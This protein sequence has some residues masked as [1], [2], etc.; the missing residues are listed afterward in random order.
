MYKVIIFDFDRTIGTLV[1]DWTNWRKNIKDLVLELEPDSDIKLEDIK[2]SNQNGLILK[3]GSEF[4]ERLNHINEQS[5]Q[6]LVTN[7]LVNKAVLDY[8]KSTDS[9]LYCWSSNSKK[10]LNKYL[11][12][13]GVI[14]RF[15]KIISREDTNLLKPDNEGFKL[16]HNQEVPLEQYLFVGDSDADKVA[17]E[18]SGII[19]MHIDDFA[20]E[21]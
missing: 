11:A 12:E 6:T 4:R 9:E 2:H 20:L 17:A 21:T 5:E 1:V 16:I 7:F 15:K 8:I 3:Y 19:F 14:D 13:I 10:T 18:K